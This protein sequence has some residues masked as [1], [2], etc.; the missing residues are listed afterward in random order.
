MEHNQE[1]IHEIQTTLGKFNIPAWLF[2]GFNNTDPIALRI[3]RFQ[4]DQWSTRRWF[5]LIPNQGE[6]RKLVHKI[7]PAI[8]DHLPGSRAVYLQW[9]QLQ[10]ELKVLLEDVSMVAMQ[11]SENNGIPYISHVDAGT[12]DLVRSCQTKVVSSENLAQY[13]EAVWSD[14]QLHQH[15]NVALALTSIVQSA[16][17]ETAMTIADRGETN[18]WAIQQ[19][20]LNQFKD[21]GLRTEHP[22]IVAVNENSANPHYQPTQY[23]YS[24]ITSGDLLLID[25]WAKSQDPDSPYGD[26]TWTAYLGAEIPHKIRKVFQVVRKARDRG[27]E[28]LQECFGANRIPQ[29][30]EVDDAVRGTIKRA[31]YAE[32]FVHR[33]GHNLGR[34]LHGNGANFDNLETHDTRLVIPGIACTIE[35]GI[36]LEGEFGIRSEINVFLSSDGPEVT[37]PP[38]NEILIAASTL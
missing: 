20:I 4:T 6:P 35:P 8:L 22:P 19:F 28:F 7:E 31:G 2:C 18:E 16:F 38:Q 33:T 17:N 30:W 23:K 21:T 27:V 9:E 10:D 3:L 11:F 34:E 5:Y 1:L 25:L 13:F 12:V 37:T 29:G 15:R 36:Y 32:C 26:I 24:K 14:E